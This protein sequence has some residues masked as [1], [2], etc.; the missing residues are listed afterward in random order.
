MD[1][2][3]KV[4]RRTGGALAVVAA[5]GLASCATVR[6]EQRDPGRC[7]VLFEQYDVLERTYPNEIYSGRSGRRIINPV[8]GRQIALIRGGDCLTLTADLAGMETYADTAEPFR[9]DAQSPAIARTYVHA[10]VVTSIS[11]EARVL[12]AFGGLGYRVRTIG[13]EQLGRRV[14]LGPFDRAADVERALA[15]ARG[16]GF[17]SAYATRYGLY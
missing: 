3:A 1:V 7:V 16:S 9:T 5:L 11:D 13:A 8:L 4:S 17:A 10:G 6:Q 14:Y 12:A 15:D 2:M